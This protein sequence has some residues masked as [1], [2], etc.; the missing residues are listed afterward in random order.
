MTQ[1]MTVR[2]ELQTQCVL[3][4][5]PHALLTKTFDVSNQ[6]LGVV[7]TR[8]LVPG[9]VIQVEI[10]QSREQKLAKVLWCLSEEVGEFRMGLMYVSHH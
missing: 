4:E 6:G 10:P 9:T 2:D 1:R 8:A 3:G 5:G 7:S